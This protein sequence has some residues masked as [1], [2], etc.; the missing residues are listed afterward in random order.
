M[1]A[2]AVALRL[3]DCVSVDPDRGLELLW[4]ILLISVIVAEIVGFVT[5]EL[6]GL[7]VFGIACIMVSIFC[8]ESIL[9][10]FAFE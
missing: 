1:A 10:R 6:V 9:G 7:P 3:E 2:F 4:L 5:A 8:Y